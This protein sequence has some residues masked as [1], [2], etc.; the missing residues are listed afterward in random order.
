M[1]HFH[2]QLHQLVDVERFDR[3]ECRHRYPA[4]DEV[5]HVMTFQQFQ[6]FGNQL[7][8]LNFDPPNTPARRPK[9][10]LLRLGTLETNG[11]RAKR[12]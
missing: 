3:A 4:A 10:L 12:G 8:L 9:L 5:H 11:R 6:I 2:G 7:A 1:V